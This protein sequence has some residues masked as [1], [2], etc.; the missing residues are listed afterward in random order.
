MGYPAYAYD[1]IPGP[2]SIR[3][4]RFDN[5][6]DAKTISVSLH[7]AH[8]DDA[9]PFFTLSYC[10]GSP[11]PCE[12][13][14]C[15][16]NQ[17]LSVTVNLAQAMRRLQRLSSEHLKGSDFVPELFWIDQ[18]CINQQDREERAEQVVLMGD[19]YTRSVRT[20]IW[21]GPVK[22]SSHPGW[23]LID[24]V[25]GVFRSENP[26]ATH[27]GD[28]KTQLYSPA[29]HA[30]RALPPLEDAL[31]GHFRQILQAPWFRRVWVIQEVALSPQDPLILHGDVM[32]PWDRL[33]WASTWLRRNGFVRLSQVPSQLL[34]VDTISNLRRS[35]V[36]WTLPA[37]LMATS[38]KFLATNPRDK[39]YGLL[40]LILESD[41]PALKPNYERSVAQVYQGVTKM[42]I[43][44]YRCLA[45]LDRTVASLD[46][47]EWF[48]PAPPEAALV[49]SWVP[50]W[51]LLTEPTQPRYL[52]WATYH[53]GKGGAHLGF[54]ANYK[55][56]AGRPAEM[57]PCA[58]IA[59]ALP[60]KPDGVASKMDD[61][62]VLQLRGLRVDTVMSTS[63]VLHP[64]TVQ[65]E[66]EAQL[67]RGMNLLTL[68]IR[69]H[70]DCTTL[71]GRLVLALAYIFLKPLLLRYWNLATHA[72][73]GLEPV[74]LIDAF[75]KCTTADLLSISG[76]SSQQIRK[77]GCAYLLTQ[78]GVAQEQ[79]GGL[80]ASMHL[81]FSTNR[82]RRAPYLE[83]LREGAEGGE[84]EAYASLARNYCLNRRFFV[85]ADRRLGIGPKWAREGDL[86]CVLFGGGVPYVVRPRP[87]GQFEFIGESYVYGLMDGQ[88]VD[89]W[90][91]GHLQQEVF[92]FC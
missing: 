85:T 14:L 23:G 78:L 62:G 49:P 41:D 75:I 79:K 17:Q 46:G 18:I 84:P 28:I 1:P 52:S 37:I 50:N 92:Q 11:E 45:I 68:P 59:D 9:P 19:I 40:G 69:P 7:I 89:A 67:S 64:F 15:N 21:L 76:K 53:G 90:R 26:D 71:F 25:Y 32:Y 65:L 10:W 88:A 16:S 51:S 34:N 43:R 12:L 86:V 44:R 3:L 8:L 73:E 74:E 38:G 33:G 63:S 91:T 87:G 35:S 82:L 83:A 61:N 70:F 2:R 13:I 58:R 56:A 42:L 47:V 39:I 57:I 80:L 6:T 60:N 31:W 22:R 81:P 27:M 48:P 30:K 66:H 55:A 54:P 36:K 77:N 4:L 5:H 24:Q 29:Q 20:L 72:C